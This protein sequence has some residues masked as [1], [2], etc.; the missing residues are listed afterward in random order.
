MCGGVYID[1]PLSPAGYCEAGAGVQAG[2]E[3]RETPGLV[4]PLDWSHTKGCLP[5]QSGCPGHSY[6]M[7]T[8][9]ELVLQIPM[10]KAR[11][12]PAVLPHM[13]WR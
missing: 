11:P 12:G 13:L 1:N 10:P 6:L 8:D 7:A 9:E 2:S 3:Q 5:Q 4:L